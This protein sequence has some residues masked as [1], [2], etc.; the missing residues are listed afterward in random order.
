LIGHRRRLQS[1]K[2]TDQGPSLG[3]ETGDRKMGPVQGT[4]GHVRVITARTA[5]CLGVA[6]AGL[7]F[8][9]SA[10]GAAGGGTPTSG[11]AYVAQAPKPS[12]LVY[13]AGFIYDKVLGRG[14]VTFVTKALASPTGVITIKS[15]PVTIYTPN[16]S[17]SGTGSGVLTITN[18]PNPG[19]ATVTDGKLLLNH[20]T[21]RLAGHSL[22][23][24]FSGT[25]NIGGTNAPDYYTFRYKG[26]YH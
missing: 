3:R 21:G 26:V 24:T 20:G 15:K 16:G 2:E 9:G 19:D 1:G 8:A 12:S 6:I 11:T 14:V 17:L 7:G 25:G 22:R 13:D 18:K 4:R 5:F 23:A 10:I